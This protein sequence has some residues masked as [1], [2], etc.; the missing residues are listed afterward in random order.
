MIRTALLVMVHGSP[1]PEANSQM[2]SVVELVR[3]RR[4]FDVVEVGFMECNEPL[5]GDAIELCVM[6][7]AER[8]IAVPYFLHTGTHVANDLPTLLDEAKLRHPQIQ[9]AMGRYVGALDR[10]TEVLADRANAAASNH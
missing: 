3:E 10:L 5:I 9:F 2:Y 6:Q 1:R 4:I 8:I 7:N